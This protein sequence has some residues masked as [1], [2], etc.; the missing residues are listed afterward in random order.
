MKIAITLSAHKNTEIVNDTIE[1]LNTYVT[2]DI[3]II[4]DGSCWENWGKKAELNAHKIQ[5]FNHNYPKA[6]YRNYT[7]GLFKTY[8]LF[9][10]ADWYAYSEYDVLFTSSEFKKELENADKQNIWCIGNDLRN[11]NFNL[12]YFEKII[13]SKIKEYKYLLGCCVFF[14]KKF[15]QKMLSENLFEKILMATNEFEKGYFPDYEEQGGYDFG[16]ILYPT[17]ANYYGGGVTQFAVWNQYLEQW[18][19]NFKKYP[20]RWKPELNWDDNFP[21]AC[22]LH[23]IK[24]SCELRMYHKSK[25]ERKKQRAKCII[26][27]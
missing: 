24:E 8:E 12:P 25:R 2:N 26:T 3:A 10:N 15:M 27:N 7:Y 19:G 14:S 21:E 13:G 16:E 20:M 9:P 17:M 5:G 22:I 18:N 6:P 23:P 1:A 11:Y 4:I